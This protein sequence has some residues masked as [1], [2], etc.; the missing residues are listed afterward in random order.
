MHV[1]LI[2]MRRLAERKATVL[3]ELID[4]MALYCLHIWRGRRA[5]LGA[6]AGGGG[7]WG[8][9]GRRR[10]VHMRAA[11]HASRR[12][13]QSACALLLLAA[14]VGLWRMMDDMDHWTDLVLMGAPRVGVGGRG[15]K[16]SLEVGMGRRML[17]ALRPCA[18]GGGP[19]SGPGPGL[20][21]S[22]PASRTAGTGD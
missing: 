4:Q 21:L 20:R 14:A 1:P 12:V 22:L 19:A 5:A 3:S 11:A 16:W 10:C 13:V 15:R 18:R 7:K 8:A 2:T 17:R 6:E 9:R